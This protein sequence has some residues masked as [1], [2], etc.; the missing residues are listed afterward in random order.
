[1]E[2]LRHA[3][4]VYLLLTMH[5]Q[6]KYMSTATCMCVCVCRTH[7][8]FFACLPF[9]HVCGIGYIYCAFDYTSVAPHENFDANKA[10][11]K[12]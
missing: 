2:S 6:I 3:N 12:D 10:H 8:V 11:S 4:V 7:I 5:M 9:I 1:M